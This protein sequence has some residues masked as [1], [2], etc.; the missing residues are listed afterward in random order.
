[1]RIEI[2]A[3]ATSTRVQVAGTDYAGWSAFI[4]QLPKYVSREF[5]LAT[6]AMNVSTVADAVNGGV[7][8]LGLRRVA[9]VRRLAAKLDVAVVG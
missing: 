3:D 9:A 5:Y 6:G 7:N 2:T 4:A 8:E 1:M